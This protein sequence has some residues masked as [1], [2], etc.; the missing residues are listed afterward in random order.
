MQEAVG[1]VLGSV[2]DLSLDLSK[3][4]GHGDVLDRDARTPRTARE[5][6]PRQH[7]HVLNAQVA[8]QSLFAGTATDK[9]A[10]SPTPTS[11]PQLDA[12]VA[13]ATTAADAL[14]R[15]RRLLLQ[16][17]AWRLLRHRLPRLDATT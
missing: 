10:L 12:L 1:R 16:V 13:G 4:T 17:A 3:A 11:S 8:G 2:Q 9:A 7:R 6:L 5:K 14:G 15:D